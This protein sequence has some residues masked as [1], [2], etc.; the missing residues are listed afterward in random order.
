MDGTKCS[1]ALKNYKL[2]LN[3]VISCLS[4]RKG[5]AKTLL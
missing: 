1:K 5:V 4:G 2:K 3:R